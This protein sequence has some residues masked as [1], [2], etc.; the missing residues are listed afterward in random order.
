LGILVTGENCDLNL[1]FSRYS[2]EHLGE[3]LEKIP[4]V[5]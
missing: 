3:N 4:G 1:I 5:A 2:G